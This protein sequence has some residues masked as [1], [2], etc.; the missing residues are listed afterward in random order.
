MADIRTK[1]VAIT[2]GSKGLGKSAAL[3]FAKTGYSVTI[4][5]RTKDEL[6]AAAADIREQVDGVTV[7]AIVADVSKPDE[8]QRFIQESIDALGS[9]QV[10]V[11]NAGLGLYGN[12]EELTEADL[13]TML[14]VN[15][16]GTVFC[17]QAGYAHMKER[18]TGH[19]INVA[20]IAGKIGLPGE[21]GYCAS[22]FAVTGFS[23]ALAAEATPHGVKVTVFCPGGI[24]T[25]FWD[26][27]THN[28]PD[29]SKFLKPDDVAAMILHIADTPAPFG[30][31][32]IIM[33]PL[34]DRH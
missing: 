2:G 32:E 27:V 11:N 26:R 34:Q 18:G 20:S 25:P 22:K 23:E 29:V 12:I 14:H 5:A 19:I 16:K 1:T 13:D 10:L 9:V 31:P 30:V 24:D 6:E 17:S 15:V 33:R 4:C 3:A 28:K 7:Q 21:S 8:C